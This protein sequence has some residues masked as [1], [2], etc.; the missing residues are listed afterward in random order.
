MSTA[1]TPPAPLSGRRV[2]IAMV[3]ILLAAVIPAVFVPTL[4]CRPADP[5]LD[6]LGVVPPFSLV[7]ERGQP[8]TEEALRGHP[9]VVDFVF[10]RCDNICPT[11]S[12]R[13]HGIQD[14]TF[15]AGK[16]LKLVSFTVDPTHDTPQVL[17]DYAKIHQADDSRWRFVT[18]A[19]GQSPDKLRTLIQD[20]FKNSM[21]VTGTQDNGAPAVG[22][23]P[24]FMLIDGDLHIRGAY[25]SG[26]LPRLD[27]L[28]RDARYL[29][30]SRKN[31]D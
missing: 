15:D 30:R 12:M 23:T 25:N 29:I 16:R 18:I 3:V 5:E 22:H 13:M 9:T 17:A 26:D 20:I 31:R 8:V 19:P 2:L 10:T 28:M 27:E 24:Y 6:D 1:V 7:D 11:M 14:K 4:A 21:K